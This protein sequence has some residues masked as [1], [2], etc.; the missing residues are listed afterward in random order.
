M[1]TI[2]NFA[3]GHA[4]QYMVYINGKTIH[5]KNLMLGRRTIQRGVYLGDTS[6][7]LLSRVMLRISSQENLKQPLSSTSVSV[8]SD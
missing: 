7:Q 3:T 8:P 1:R 4:M 6:L 2:E 5:D